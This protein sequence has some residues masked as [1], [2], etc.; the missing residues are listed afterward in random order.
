MK[1]KNLSFALLA[2]GLAMSCNN[3]QDTSVTTDSSSTTGTT[4]D[5]TA[6]TTAMAPTVTTTTTVHLDPTRSY[7]DLK[8]GKKV[9]LRVDTVTKYIVN[10]V[11]NQP[12]MYYIDPSTRDTFDR[13]GRM[14]S[15]ALIRSASGDYSID[16]SRLGSNMSDNSGSDNSTMSSSDTSSSM[17]AGSTTGGSGKTKEKIKDDK[18]KYK[19]QNTK[20]KVKTNQ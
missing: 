16:E 1:F 13:Q 6:T 7:V 17:S 8:S 11:T 14:V 3:S 9:R 19:D 2:A 15:R 12:I 5:T 18:Y 20:V 10:E 4:V